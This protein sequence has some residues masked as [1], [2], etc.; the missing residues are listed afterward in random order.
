M[1][2]L[3]SALLSVFILCS[4]LVAKGQEE[5]VLLGTWSDES[6]IGS[7]FYNNIYNEVWGITFGGREYAIVG[8]TAGTHF[9]DV[10]DPSMA[11][12]AHFVAGASQGGQII[13]RDF[14]DKNGILYS[15]SDEGSSSLQIID[16]R[17]L[18]DTVE[19]IYDS[20]S[21]IRNTHNIFIEGNTMYAFATF[22]ATNGGYAMRLF[23][24]SNPAQPE[25]VAEY[26]KFGSLSVG[27]VHDGYVR[28]NI[29]FLNCGGDGMAI[30]DFND[31]LNPVTL[32]ELTSYPDQGY[33]HSG[34]LTDDGSYYYMADEN[35]AADLKVLDVSD[36]CNTSVKGTFN[37]GVSNTLSITHNQIVSCDYLYTS[38]YYDGL[39]VFDISDP[40]SPQKV[41]YYDSYPG[42]D[43]QS[44]KGAWGVYPLLP[45]GNIL[46]T[47]MQ[48]GLYVLDGPDDDCASGQVLE[49]PSEC[50]VVS[51]ATNIELQK[52]SM[53][54]YPQPGL[55]GQEITISGIPAEG[56]ISIQLVG[57]NGAV[58]MNHKQ[59]LFSKSGFA[60]SLPGGISPGIYYLH[61]QSSDNRYIKPVC[62]N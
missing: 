11:F 18:P 44:Y 45:S 55:A 50:G 52:Q 9:I 22:G 16:F 34:W 35:H 8:S 51:A 36:P 24:I 6:L 47:D 12:E 14:H 7:N 56:R 48:T 33:N 10:T 62:V 31:R 41:L 60:L 28:N 37:A 53:I 3:R 49:D 13:H 61:I 19:V 29:A 38:Y 42:A 5:A 57:S 30:V 46:V 2:N 27:H 40:E 17:G 1:L 15:V 26:N 4:F 21:L 32:Y 23:D 58:V 25:F 39:Q 54:V 59:E 43:A 20:D